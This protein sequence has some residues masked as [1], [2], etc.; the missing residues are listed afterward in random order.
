M[1]ERG[2]AVCVTI[3]LSAAL[4]WAFTMHEPRVVPSLTVAKDELA[5]TGRFELRRVQTVA[6]GLAY[7]NER[8]IYL[9]IDR[10]TGREYVG[11]SGIGIAE[12]GRHQVGKG[13]IE[14]ER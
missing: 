9:L 6:D 10:E 5:P 1:K 14:D 11:V 12:L 13:S 3:A 7:D 8:G 4:V 2:C